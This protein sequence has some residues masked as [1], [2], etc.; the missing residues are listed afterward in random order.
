MSVLLMMDGDQNKQTERSSEGKRMEKKKLYYHECSHRDKKDIE[1]M[2]KNMMLFLR[3]EHSK[4][5]KNSWKLKIWEHTENTQYKDA[6]KE[7]KIF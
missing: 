1:F 2:K 4:N 6:S 3:K 7:D 5:K